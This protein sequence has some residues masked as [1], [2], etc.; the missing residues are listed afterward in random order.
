M[1]GPETAGSVRT[2][3][4]E[5]DASGAG[6]VE[7]GADESRGADGAPPEGAGLDPGAG[8]GG[9]ERTVAAL[10]PA[11]EPAG[12]E[13]DTL[14]GRTASPARGCPELPEL[15]PPSER[16]CPAP[17]DEPA[18]SCP[19]AALWLSRFLLDGTNN[20]LAVGGP[21]DD[22][23]AGGGGGGAAGRDG[24]GCR[25]VA[26]DDCVVGGAPGLADALDEPGRVGEGPGVR[27]VAGASP[28]TGDDTVGIA[29]VPSDGGFDEPA[30]SP[31][32]P[33]DAE[34]RSGSS[35]PEEPP[36]FAEPVPVR[37]T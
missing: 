10:P 8:R 22:A 19:A 17:S 26:A 14:D 28:F 12:R 32:E 11:S 30:P 27:T 21:L 5:I 18:F 16:P 34:D 23:G 2:V 1:V 24:R 7:P 6:V 15:E 37:D 9:V 31:P 4:P 25:M 3:G 35:A 13:A 29:R 33:F 20:W 36:R